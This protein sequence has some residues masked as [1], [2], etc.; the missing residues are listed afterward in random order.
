ML[1]HFNYLHTRFPQ[2]VPGVPKIKDGYNPATWMLDISDPSVE[3]QLNVDFA[4]VYAKSSLYQ[5]AFICTHECGLYSSIIC[6][7]QFWFFDICFRRNQELIKE[8][9]TPPPGSQDLYFPTQ[10]SRSFFTQ[11][12][13]CFWKQYWSYWRNPQY[14]AIRFLMTTIIGILFGLIFYD[15]GQKM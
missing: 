12:R 11:C 13:A 6:R 2:A 5:Y 9:S 4:D 7:Y 1:S 8:L 3:A 15:K 14:N 10:F